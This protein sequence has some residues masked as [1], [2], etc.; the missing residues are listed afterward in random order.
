VKHSSSFVLSVALTA[1]VLTTAGCE[2]DLKI[3]G[4]AKG[5]DLGYKQ[6]VARPR[7]AMGSPAI[8]Q[9]GDTSPDQQQ[10][11]ALPT[12][13]RPANDVNARAAAHA[14]H[15]TQ[16]LQN[17]SNDP[18][19]LPAQQAGTDRQLIDIPTTPT[20]EPITVG[21]PVRQ[22]AA[23]TSQ[24]PQTRT[25]SSDS[26]QVQWIDVRHN[27]ARDESAPSWSESSAYATQPNVNREP[28]AEDRL[29]AAI[30]R[31]GRQP[32]KTG[33]SQDWL[34]SDVSFTDQPSDADTPRTTYTN[35]VSA[36]PQTFASGG[37]RQA[38][39]VQLLE[40][41]RG[42]NDPATSKVMAL[43][44]LSMINPEYRLTSEDLAG[45]TPKQ[46][47]LVRE[48]YESVLK[49]SRRIAE[50][51][52]RV[53]PAALA[54]HVDQIFG[55]QPLRIS[56][57]Q[58]C[59]SVSGFGVYEAFNNTTFQG[60]REQAVILYVE[61]ENFRIVETG[62]AYQ[63]RLTQE[64]ELYTDSDG[65]RVWY[66]PKQKIVD[67]SQNRRR[68]FFTVQMLRLPARLGVGKYRLK[69]RLTDETAGSFDEWTVPID[70]VVTDT[71]ARV[72]FMK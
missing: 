60:G 29:L 5:P 34:G 32:A 28:T 40:D 52:G 50:N 43:S 63:V 13:K 71:T 4:I 1:A 25:Y 26:S 48:F 3:P 44:A 61:L 64:V 35:A 56:K 42:S 51:G 2:F 18:V 68:D 8:R 66:Q 20:G 22:R 65:L 24:S 9:A 55:K 67:D 10:A 31:A 59:K 6:G 41:I 49:T 19:V 21:Q 12:K 23:A 33:N 14:E 57:V 36:Q 70:L 17:R 58:L 16:A 53:D 46:R 54:D 15:L 47:Q 39:L 45:L 37:D 72:E 38:L 62:E 7:V 69:I 27:S 11:P 30:N